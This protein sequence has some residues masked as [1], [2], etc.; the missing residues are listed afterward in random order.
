MCTGLTACK[1]SMLC[2]H[3]PDVPEPLGS[4]AAYSFTSIT[5]AVL[6]CLESSSLPSSHRSSHATSEHSWRRKTFHSSPVVLFPLP[7]SHLR[8]FIW[9]QKVKVYLCQ[10]TP[11]SRSSVLPFCFMISLP[12]HKLGRVEIHDTCDVSWKS[13]NRAAQK[14]QSAF[15][16]VSHAAA[17]ARE[18]NRDR[19]GVQQL[20]RASLEGRK[21]ITDSTTCFHMTS[22]WQDKWHP[23]W[24]ADGCLSMSGLGQTY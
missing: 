8:L 14:S 20:K 17:T 9:L 13:G 12:Q 1:Y 23:H 6:C 5:S 16:C 7:F 22:D 21:R 11:S 2:Y 10:C 19:K 15:Q 18:S 4:S 24:K 3:R